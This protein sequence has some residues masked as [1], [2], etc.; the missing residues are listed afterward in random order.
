MTTRRGTTFASMSEA[1]ESGTPESS[2]LSSIEPGL[3]PL[4]EAQAEIAALRAQL[5]ARATETPEPSL[6]RDQLLEALLS[7]LQPH[8]P[9]VDTIT[10]RK[11]TKLPDPLLLSDGKDPAYASWKLQIEDKLEV[12][13]DHFRT[14]D[15]CMAYVFSRT[16]GDAQGHL[17]P[18]YGR[19]AAQRFCTA[20]DMLDYLT[21][22]FE[23]PFQKENA[24]FAYK[25]DFMGKQDKNEAFTV[26]Y[27]RF[28]HLAGVAGIPTEDLMPDLFDKLTVKLQRTLLPTYD[29][30]TTVQELANRC[31][32][33]DQWHRRLDAKSERARLQTLPAMKSPV[34]YVR[35]TPVI[36]A[37]G[38]QRSATPVDRTRPAYDNAE[39]QRQLN[40]G[41]CFTCHQPGHISRDCP[42]QKR[43]QS[44]N[45]VAA[46][47]GK[48]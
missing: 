12:N 24:R 11:S 45:E 26:F 14:E 20:Q 33:Q 16:T 8:E 42:Q 40:L 13:A 9:S 41:L 28:L 37:P 4:V 10:D 44:L 2:E 48:E 6:S 29:A 17:Q 23:D 15:A 35:N 27:T 19:N 30:L 31:S 38:P 5:A 25:A 21:A 46:E 7:R 34:P 22:I 32:F 39:R 18:R 47:S 3:D 1:Q 36:A 43:D